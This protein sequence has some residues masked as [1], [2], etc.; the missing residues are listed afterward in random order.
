MNTL[1]I[2]SSR[3]KET[4]ETLSSR[5]EVEYNG[6][7]DFDESKRLVAVASVYSPFE[8]HNPNAIP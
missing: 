8:R 6:D 3:W 5:P 4:L 1:E 7:E 2:Y